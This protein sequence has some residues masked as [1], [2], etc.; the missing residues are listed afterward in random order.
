[1]QDKLGEL[2]VRLRVT[3]P[4]NPFRGA[5]LIVEVP[6][7]PVFTVTLD[8]VADMVKSGGAGAVTVTLTLVVEPEAVAPTGLPLTTR[9]KGPVGVEAVVEIVKTSVAPAKVGVTV[10]EAKLQ[11][12]PVG[13]GV[14]HE[15][16]TGT[17]VP[18]VKVAVIVTVPELPAVIVTGPLFDNE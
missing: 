13:R 5:T 7:T 8:G 10:G 4:V 15:R 11:E 14:M 16:V 3:V 17:A 2:V 1:V 12:T 18:A 9:V 6:W